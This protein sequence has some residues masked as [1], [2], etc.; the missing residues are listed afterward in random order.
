MELAL[1][2]TWG[3]VTGIIVQQLAGLDRFLDSWWRAFGMG[4]SFLVSGLV[5]TSTSLERFL[6]F[7]VIVL[8]LRC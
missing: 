8:A 6:W 1:L 4:G 5:V 7:L 3:E 2:S